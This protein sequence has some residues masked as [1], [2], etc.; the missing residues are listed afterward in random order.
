MFSD[1]TVIFPR[2]NHINC[3]SYT[4]DCKVECGD[5]SPI[6]GF[7]KQ[8]PQFE[9]LGLSLTISF[10]NSVPFL[11]LLLRRKSFGER[12]AQSI[13]EFISQLWIIT[14]KTPYNAIHDSLVWNEY[15]FLFCGLY[16]PVVNVS[17]PFKISISFLYL[18]RIP[19]ESNLSCHNSQ[20][21]SN[22]A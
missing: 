9:C 15:L 17:T 21:F 14:S 12:S 19:P 1:S 16:C 3:I 5:A 13:L 10:Q 6:L 20:L 4:G 22:T 7:G 18:K 2:T 11:I 8:H